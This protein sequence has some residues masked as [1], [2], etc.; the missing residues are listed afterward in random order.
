MGCFRNPCF[1]LNSEHC[2]T[3]RERENKS[4]TGWWS[5]NA[6][7]NNDIDSSYLFRITTSFLPYRVFYPNNLQPMN[8]LQYVT[9]SMLR[10]SQTC[11]ASKSKT[12][13]HLSRLSSACIT[14]S[15][16]RL[17]VLQ[18]RLSGPSSMSRFLA[19]GICSMSLLRIP[20]SD[21]DRSV[22]HS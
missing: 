9:S 1:L 16:C 5:L 11:A 2:G 17:Q 21:A 3:P 8:N 4:A 14:S 22:G 15:Q 18:H 13:K 19:T 20:S 6:R 12:I 10:L 7:E